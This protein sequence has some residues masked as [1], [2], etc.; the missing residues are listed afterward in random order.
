[1]KGLIIHFEVT[2]GMEAE[3]ERAM[4][5][6]V[7]NVRTRDPSYSLYS[8]ARVRDEDRR[9]VLVQQFESYE[10]QERHQT[11]DYVLEAMTPINA[12]LAAIPTIEWLDLID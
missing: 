6:H 2:A 11:Y 7:H 9:Y 10:S 12:C 1:M 3:F 5:V 4:G 8:L